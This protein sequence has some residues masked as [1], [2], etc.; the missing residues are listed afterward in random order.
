MEIDDAVST[1]LASE[2]YVQLFQEGG[3][4]AFDQRLVL[5]SGIQG[6][7]YA[8]RAAEVVMPGLVRAGEERVC[9]LAFTDGSV[10]G[11]IARL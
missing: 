9:Y 5:D 11:V 6:E 3:D 4:S 7:T 8:N 1:F 2:P 10:N